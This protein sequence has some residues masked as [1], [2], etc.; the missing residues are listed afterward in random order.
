MGPLLVGSTGKSAWVLTIEASDEGAGSMLCTTTETPSQGIETKS[1]TRMDRKFMSLSM[2]VPMATRRQVPN[3]QSDARSV[4]PVPVHHL[5]RPWGGGVAFLA[6]LVRRACGWPAR[7]PRQG[8]AATMRPVKVVQ[9]PEVGLCLAFDSWCPDLS[10][11]PDVQEQ[12]Q[13]QSI[14]S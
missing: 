14:L 6:L 2:A 7:R 4:Y 12:R 8:N 11:Q 13:C 9:G 3:R 10:G 5:Q 1:P